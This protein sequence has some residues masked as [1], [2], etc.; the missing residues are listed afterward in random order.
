M[1]K[2][3]IES[4]TLIEISRLTHARLSSI[5]I[6]K[7]KSFDKIINELLNKEDQRDFEEYTKSKNCEIKS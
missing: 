5:K 6:G 4:K 7:R 1:N 2:N 3:N